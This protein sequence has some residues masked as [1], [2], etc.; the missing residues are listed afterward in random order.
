[1]NQ[2]HFQRI[3][4]LLLL[5]VGAPFALLIQGHSEELTTPS[6]INSQACI[7]FAGYST[8]MS[9]RLAEWNDYTEPRRFLH[10]LQVQMSYAS[11][12]A[13]KLGGMEAMFELGAKEELRIF[14][15]KQMWMH[16][17]DAYSD[18]SMRWDATK[19][20]LQSRPE[21]ETQV[22]KDVLAAIR[23]YMEDW[24]KV[25]LKAFEAEVVKLDPDF[26]SSNK[27]AIEADQ[28]GD[29][30]AIET[31]EVEEVPRNKTKPSTE[32]RTWTS[33][34]KE[35][36][37]SFVEFVGDDQIKLRVDKRIFVFPIGRL[38]DADKKFLGYREPLKTKV[39]EVSEITS[40]DDHPNA[41]TKKYIPRKSTSRDGT[42]ILLRATGVIGSG[43][44]QIQLGS[45]SS[46]Q[47]SDAG[48]AARREMQRYQSHLNSTL[49]PRR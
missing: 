30:G 31:A 6:V 1:M 12:M 35:L 34:G 36:T 42:D 45:P 22:S 24:V 14:A 21:L 5:T 41:A 8:E 43:G 16:Y 10:H 13:S 28:S 46:Y 26:L 32:K 19:S 40:N 9:N 33:N 49:A 2:L 18:L 7:E 17:Q 15:L 47:R 4:H 29:S 27:P 38:S 37:A 11:N 44:N 20:I 3:I 39:P 48:E 25:R 23:P